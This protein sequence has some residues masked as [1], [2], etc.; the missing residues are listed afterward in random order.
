MPPGFEM[1]GIRTSWGRVDTDVARDPRWPESARIS[2][3]DDPF[4]LA[5]ATDASARYGRLTDVE[6]AFAAHRAAR[7]LHAALREIERL[8]RSSENA[9]AVE[10]EA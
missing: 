2:N 10:D 8:R 9:L 6:V 1:L 7:H 3:L 5:A 4:D